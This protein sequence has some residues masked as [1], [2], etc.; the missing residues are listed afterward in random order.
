MSL[1]QCEIDT[2]ARTIYGEARGEYGNCEGGICSLIAVGNVVMNRVKAKT[3][4]GNSIQDVCYKPKQFSCWNDGD[5]NLPLLQ[6]KIIDPIFDICT[7][8]ASKVASDEWPDITKGSD[9]YH[10][11]SISPDWAAGQKP[12]VRIAKHLFYKL[13]NKG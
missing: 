2:L 13:N 1:L 5:P 7:E 6:G 3:W 11:V 8:V 10:T 9:H 4:F 12:K